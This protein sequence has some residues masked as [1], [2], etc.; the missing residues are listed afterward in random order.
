MLFRSE[1]IFHAVISVLIF[2]LWI[3]IDAHPDASHPTHPH[4]LGHRWPATD[5]V[6][7]KKK[8]VRAVLARSPIWVERCKPWGKGYYFGLSY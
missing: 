4:S 6:W 2:M 8:A 1:Q 7:A 5:S 3:L